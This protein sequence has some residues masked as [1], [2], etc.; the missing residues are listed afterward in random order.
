[1]LGG[2]PDRL[3]RKEGRGN[4]VGQKLTNPRQIGLPRSSRRC[5]QAN[6]GR[7]VRSPPA[8]TPRSS[9]PA[10]SRQYRASGY[11]SSH[12]EASRGHRAKCFFRRICKVV[13]SLTRAQPAPGLNSGFGI[14]ALRLLI[15]GQNDRRSPI[16]NPALLPRALT[17]GLA[18][19]GDR[20]LARGA[21]PRPR[22]TRSRSE[23]TGSPKPSMAGFSR[24]LPTAP[25]RN[26][27]SMSPSCR[28]ARTITTACC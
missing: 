27:G 20:D 26:T 19:R 9:A 11:R 6:A 24:R 15:M 1:M 8:A 5:Q 21:T 28:A 14:G 16:M 23:P 12:G 18:G 3:Q 13:V 4:F 10:R 17:A 25:T 2:N 22:W 7:A